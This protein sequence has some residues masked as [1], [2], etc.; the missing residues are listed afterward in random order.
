MKD[1]KSIP[2]TVLKDLFKEDGIP[3][4]RAEQIFLWL[5]KGSVSTFDEMKN[6]PKELRAKLG[7]KYY[8]SVAKVE[9]KLIS[10]YDNT[11]KYLYR[12]YDGHTVESVLMSY[13]HGNT[14]CL[15]TQVGCKMGCTFCATGKQGFKR[16][17]TAGEML[18]QVQASQI[19]S[20]R[21]IN[22]LVL[23]G[24][25]EPLDNYENVLD[26]LS[27]INDEKGLNIGMRHITLSTCGICDKIYDLADK[28]TQINLSV[29]LHAPNDT[30][31]QKTMPINK[32]YG[33][34]ELLRACEYYAEQTR[35]RITFEYALIADVNDS[36]K[37]AQELASKL[38]N[39]HCHVN[40]IPVNPVK[41]AEYKPAQKKKTIKFLSVLEKGGINATVRRT[42]GADI[43]ASCGQ[44]KSE[45]LTQNK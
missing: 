20:G 45:T 44:L 7:E 23:M 27:I 25:G 11:I 22:N 31:R 16:N 15:S 19:D 34:D 6:I 9:K 29:S 26:F 36:E 14:L 1:I 8:I 38:K 30:M 24:M 10:C 32:K 17:L 18:C 3:A 21:K 37:N 4:F 28:K 2:L 39:I 33:I 40:L 35:R 12:L 43:N 13:H 5:Q 41:G 42:L